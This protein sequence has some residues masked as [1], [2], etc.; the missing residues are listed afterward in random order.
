MF[1]SAERRS[2]AADRPPARI[3]H[4]VGAAILVIAMTASAAQASPPPDD[5][6]VH[7]IT[8]PVVD[9]RVGTATTDGTVAVE[10]RDKGTT[11][12]LDASVLFAKDS[13]VLKR[14]ARARINVLA[15][16]L[17]EAG[18]GRITVTGFTDDLGSAAHG[19]RLSRHR[20]AAVA[21]QLGPLL[22]PGWPSP[23]IVGMGEDDPAVPNTSEANRR[24]NRRVVVTVEH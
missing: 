12:R 14:G 13:A 10:Q 16:R 24:L 3:G 21:D 1:R 2:P 19:M 15:Q 23:T 11:A 22:G 18:T 4:S 17:R 7:P 8:M 20:A 5:A 6:S 9:I